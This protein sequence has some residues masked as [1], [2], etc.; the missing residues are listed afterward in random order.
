MP[1]G[2]LSEP[3]TNY[4]YTKWKLVLHT[5]KVYKE[6]AKYKVEYSNSWSSTGKWLL[7]GF[8]YNFQNSK[9]W[10]RN[11]DFSHNTGQKIC[12]ELT[13]LR[14][15]SPRHFAHCDD[16]CRCRFRVH[17]TL[18]HI[19][20]VNGKD[21]EKLVLQKGNVKELGFWIVQYYVCKNTTVTSLITTTSR[22]DHNP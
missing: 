8:F 13:R 12:C 21:P 18:N 10:L 5:H 19:R 11:G 17:T 14:L 16:Y 20:F 1:K 4:L 6:S 9:E 15:V 7:L 3:L 2:N 22:G